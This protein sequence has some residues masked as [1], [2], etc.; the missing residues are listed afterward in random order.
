MEIT[1][2]CYSQKQMCRDVGHGCAHFI[3]TLC[4]NAKYSV[5]VKTI[6]IIIYTKVF[7]RD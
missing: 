3:I 2:F 7:R 4:V 6:A 1:V 5:D